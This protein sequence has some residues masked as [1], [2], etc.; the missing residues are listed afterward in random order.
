MDESPHGR[1]P[2]RIE[3]T[4]KTTLYEL[5]DGLGS[6]H[7]PRILEHAG[8]GVAVLV[9][10]DEFEL[11]RSWRTKENAVARALNAAG[12]WQDL[13]TDAMIRRIYEVR[14]ESPADPPARF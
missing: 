12:A 13:D 1:E 9:S 2:K 10:I 14:H 8:M 11:L 4:P 3:I 5:L 6:D 7:Q